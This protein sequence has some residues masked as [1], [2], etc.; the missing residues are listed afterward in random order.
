MFKHPRNARC[1]L[2]IVDVPHG[3]E[4]FINGDGLFFE[5]QHSTYIM[6]SLLAN[7]KVVQRLRASSGVFHYIQAHVHLFTCRILSEGE[8]DFT[9]LFGFVCA[10]GSAP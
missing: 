3:Q 6:Y 10:V 1:E 5:V 7:D 4:D 2:Q 8:V 9:H